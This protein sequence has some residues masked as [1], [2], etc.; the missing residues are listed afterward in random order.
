[1]HVP[2]EQRS[3]PRPVPAVPSFGDFLLSFPNELGEFAAIPVLDYELSLAQDWLG[4]RP[5]RL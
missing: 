2:F 5:W 4:A 1:M 3:S